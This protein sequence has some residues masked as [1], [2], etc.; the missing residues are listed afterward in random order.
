[1]CDFSSLFSKQMN[2]TCISASFELVKL[3]AIKQLLNQK[4]KTVTV[5]KTDGY[6]RIK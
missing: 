6:V 3:I 1:M 5:F 4:I 2:I